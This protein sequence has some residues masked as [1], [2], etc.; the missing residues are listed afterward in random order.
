MVSTELLRQVSIFSDL[1]DE[2]LT[3]IAG[4]CREEAHQKGDVIVRQKEPS[5][6]LYIIRE[7]NAEVVLGVPSGAGPTPILHLGKGQVFGEMSLI[8]KGLRS[9]TVRATADGTVLYALSRDDF[10]ELCDQDTRIGYVVM[11]NLA[12]DLSFK[13]RHYNLAWR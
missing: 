11:R 10:I 2:Q 7:G 13:L 8:D 6:D 1:S 3:R 9:A 12:A 4:I 5:N